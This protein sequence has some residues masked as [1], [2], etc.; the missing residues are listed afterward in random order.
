MDRLSNSVILSAREREWLENPEGFMK[1]H[2]RNYSYVVKHRV[3]GKVA[4]ALVE[5]PDLARQSGNLGVV[6]S[7][8][9]LTLLQAAVE[10]DGFRLRLGADGAIES[11]MAG[12][13]TFLQHLVREGVVQPD[14]ANEAKGEG[15]A[16]KGK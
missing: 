14:E 15:E 10:S 3:V 8:F 4:D 16:G 2:G 5:L 11:L 7:M 6:G 9:K 1:A 12:W 13:K